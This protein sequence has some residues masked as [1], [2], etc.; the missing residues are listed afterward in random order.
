MIASG[1]IFLPG[2]GTPGSSMT[3]S[4][5]LAFQSR[6]AVSGAAQLHDVDLANVTGTAALGRHRRRIVRGGQ[7]RR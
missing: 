7:Q 3:V 5:N 4:G 1:G 6:R 2:N